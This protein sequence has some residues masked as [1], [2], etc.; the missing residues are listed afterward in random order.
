MPS[1]NVAWVFA[2][3]SGSLMPIRLLKKRMCG[4]VAS[5]TPTMPISLDSTSRIRHWSGRNVAANAAAVIQPAVP[6]PTMTMRKGAGTSSPDLESKK[7]GAPQ[8]MRRAHDREQSLLEPVTDAEVESA[9]VDEPGTGQHHA[10]VI[11]LL[12]QH[13]LRLEQVLRVEEHVPRLARLEVQRTVELAVRVLPD[14]Q[15]DTAVRLGLQEL[16]TP[17]V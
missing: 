17:V 1:L 13:R 11:H 8:M 16:V 7:R 5:P 2:M 12:P 4:S 15:L 14:R 6:P 3:S 10:L 9:I